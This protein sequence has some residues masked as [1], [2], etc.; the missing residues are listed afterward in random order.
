[1]SLS[2]K[3][4][5]FSAVLNKEFKGEIWCTGFAIRPDGAVCCIVCPILSIP[6]A[7]VCLTLLLGTENF[8][9]GCHPGTALPKDKEN[10]Y[11]FVYVLKIYLFFFFE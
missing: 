9:V 8:H 5:S 3:Y 7:Y 4:S 10:I 2:T 1:M 6:N 11:Y